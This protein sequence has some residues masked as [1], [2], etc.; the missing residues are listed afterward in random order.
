VDAARTDEALLV[1]GRDGRV[2]GSRELAG[3]HSPAVP[4]PTSESIQ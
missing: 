1:L 4:P 3:S 2:R